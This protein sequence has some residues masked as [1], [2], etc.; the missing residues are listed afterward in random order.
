M[1]CDVNGWIAG[2]LWPYYFIV[3]D[4]K[5]FMHFD[6]APADSHTYDLNSSSVR[7]RR[8]LAELHRG[9]AGCFESGV[10]A[11]PLQLL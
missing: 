8:E 11:G 3:Q 5:E 2:K 10:L 6:T 1:P 7:S 4:S 9:I